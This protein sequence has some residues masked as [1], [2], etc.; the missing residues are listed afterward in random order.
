MPS[1]T[2]TRT[3]PRIYHLI[4]LLIVIL[5]AG[6]RLSAI[7]RTMRWDEGRTFQRFAQHPPSEF[8]LDYSDP[9]NHFMNSLMIHIQYR[10]LGDDEDWKLRVHVLVIG[11]LVTVATYYTG[12]E[13][14]DADVGLMAS[15]LSS[16]MYMLVEFSINA[17]GYIIMTLIF[18]LLVILINRMKTQANWRGWLAIGCLSALGFFV[19]PAF[20]YPM[21]TLGLWMFLSILT[22]NEGHDRRRIFAYFVGAMIV[23]AMLS[24]LIYLPALIVTYGS[25]SALNQGDVIRY[26]R[27]VDDFFTTTLPAAVKVV[28]ELNHTGMPII[29]ILV[30][31][32]GAMIAMI[33]HRKFSQNR[34]PLFLTI[35]MWTALQLVVQ[36]T[37]IFERVFTFITPIYAILIATGLIALVRHLTRYR[38]S[39]VWVSIGLSIILVV[40]IAYQ[41][42]N[43]QLLFTAW[44]TASMP[45]GRDVVDVLQNTSFD[46]PLLTEGRYA[47]VLKYYVNR[48]DIDVSVIGINAEGLFDNWEDGQSFYYIGENYT[49]ISTI[50]ALNYIELTDQNLVLEPL[51]KLT[52]HYQL[53]EILRIP[54]TLKAITS[55]EQVEGVWF[56]KPQR[57]SYE[58]DDQIL[59]FSMFGDQWKLLQ[60]NYGKHWQ[61]YIL[62]TRIKITSLSEDFEEVLIG[63]RA[64]DNTRYSF[65]LNLGEASDD[66]QVG[67]RLDV[68]NTYLGYIDIV[69][70]TLKLNQEYDIMIEVN[71]DTFTA[72]IDGEQVLQSSDDTLENGSISFL[73]SPDTTVQLTD[74]RLE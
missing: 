72:F 60:Y 54:P 46:K 26:T 47:E 69:P 62:S 41:L 67:F 13:L 74:I 14:Y 61:D 5:S 58:L 56:L 39:R 66:G 70:Y 22:E 17:R 36:Q 9:N 31:L 20:L 11:V 24:V 68:N 19:S 42:V 55:L 73:A 49:R 59:T 44:I 53:Y 38:L 30:C 65:A 33:F 1:T 21:G 4:L 7:N 63:F 18:L 50:L 71:G 16:V 27:P 40:P 6:I 64:I 32:T 2:S 12:K 29:L 51:Q 43:Q 23:G 25:V 57:V 37:V 8:L 35:P 34:V 10:L 3:N 48:D 52:E 15:A 45:Y 28:F